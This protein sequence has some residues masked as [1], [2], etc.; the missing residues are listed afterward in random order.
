[1]TVVLWQLELSHYNE[2][3]RW[4]LAYK[5]IEHERRS[6]MPGMH[7]LR[8]MALTRS[9]HRRLPVAKIDVR[10]VADSTAIIAALEDYK[11]EPPLYPSDPG[12]R[13]RALELEEFF[14]EQLAT[15][16]R[17][18]VW[19]HTLDDADATVGA[20]FTRPAPARER[21]LR[22]T[23]PLIRPVVRRD[24]GISEK[25]AAVSRRSI[26]EAMD[27]VEAELRPSGY[28]VGDSFSVADLAG[29]ALFTPLLAPAGREYQPA[30]MADPVLELR[31]ELD[32]RPG[33]RWVHEMFARHR[34][35]SPE[36]GDVAAAVTAAV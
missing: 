14:D 26:V 19:H 33:G 23:A 35:Q 9:G 7:G 18:F 27:R 28:L 11:P 25:T 20:L 16:V 22:M 3:V 5:G 6:P 10:I 24:F 15:D 31:A 30:T 36:S 17:R 29:A 4:A 21:L 34:A 32:A 8:A 12:E 13:A 1:M 2:K